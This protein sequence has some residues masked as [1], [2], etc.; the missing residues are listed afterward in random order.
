MEMSQLSHVLL[1]RLPVMVSVA[2]FTIAVY[3]VSSVWSS[4]SNLP[5]LG[6][7]NGSSEQRRK[8]YRASAAKL[9]QKGYELFRHQAYRLTTSDG[10]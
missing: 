1:D 5:L 2:L 9:Y 8:Q 3:A 6:A 7:D 10:K 4:K